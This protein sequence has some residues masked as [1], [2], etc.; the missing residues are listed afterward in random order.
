MFLTLIR[1]KKN[2]SSL[3]SSNSAAVGGVNA[4]VRKPRTHTL[5][6]VE[7]AHAASAEP[8]QPELLRKLKKE[9]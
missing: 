8:S 1:N 2:S 4:P 6:G 5:P 3:R 7:S 9:I